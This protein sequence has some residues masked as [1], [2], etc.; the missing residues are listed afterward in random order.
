MSILSLVLILALF[1]LQMVCTGKMEAEIWQGGRESK[2]RTK[3]SR[4]LKMVCSTCFIL[5]ALLALIA[6]TGFTTFAGLML[7]AFVLSWFGDLFLHFDKMFPHQAIGFVC[8]IAAHVIFIV[9]FL[10]EIQVLDPSQKAFPVLWI[11]VVLALWVISCV[12]LF[13]WAKVPVGPLMVA[14]LVYMLILCTMFGN[15]IRLG[16]VVWN[17]GIAG[18]ALGTITLILGALGFF[19]SDCSMAFLKFSSKKEY[20][21]NW[22]IDNFNLYTYYIGQSLLAFSLMFIS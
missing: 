10:K 3:K 6:N 7:L 8:F 17:E 12:T 15:A 21:V 5:I 22:F 11:I 1:V 14:G 9:A 4:L 18:S 13:L 2:R 20:N 19:V 16:I